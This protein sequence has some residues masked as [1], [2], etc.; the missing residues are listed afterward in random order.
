M[1]S[2][3]H[4]N[5]G[6]MLNSSDVGLG[7]FPTEILR[8]VFVYIYPP[9]YLKYTQE[10]DSQPNGTTN[11]NDPTDYGADGEPRYF[12]LPSIGPLLV[13]KRFYEIGY[14]AFL[15]SFTGHV[16]IASR[17]LWKELH[18]RYKGV[19]SRAKDLTIR[20]DHMWSFMKLNYIE[21]LPQVE[22]LT[23]VVKHATRIALYYSLEQSQINLKRPC[24]FGNREYSEWSL[25][26][27]SDI[28]AELPPLDPIV[29]SIREYCL[30]HN[31]SLI[32]RRLFEAALP[33][34]EEE[35]ARVMMRP[36]VSV[37]SYPDH[38]PSLADIL[39]AFMIS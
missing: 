31:V 35:N 34:D 28:Q 26:T 6:N 23:L 12:I 32:Y 2:V 15:D 11:S 21:K 25:V 13:C 20:V 9:W 36:V 4:G 10:H 22:R 37:C 38:V 7:S 8:Q 16:H 30:Y 24:L 27:E 29:D 39:S 19:M 33:F 1:V 5:V 14:D 17:L 18:F 3:E